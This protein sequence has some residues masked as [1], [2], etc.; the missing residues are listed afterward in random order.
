[1]PGSFQQPAR[2]ATSLYTGQHGQANWPKMW[3]AF[4][5]SRFAWLV[6]PGEA[7]C[8]TPSNHISMLSKP[9]TQPTWHL[10]R[11]STVKN[12]LAP[13]RL[14]PYSLLLPFTLHPSVLPKISSTLHSGPSQGTQYFRRVHKCPALD[15]KV[16]TECALPSVRPDPQQPSRSLTSDTS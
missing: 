5:S 3:Q 12:I 15:R 10:G 2:A 8:R 14:L 1:M 11:C 13:E 4:L 9:L 16:S 6:P 7:F